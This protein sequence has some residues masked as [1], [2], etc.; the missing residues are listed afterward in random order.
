MENL[1]LKL[2]NKLDKNK[3]N[4]IFSFKHFQEPHIRQKNSSFK[5]IDFEKIGWSDLGTEIM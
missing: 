4:F 2:I 5:L 3:I 1:Y